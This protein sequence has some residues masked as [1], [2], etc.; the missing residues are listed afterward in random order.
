MAGSL[1][2]HRLRPDVTLV[3]RNGWI[4]LAGSGQTLRLPDTERNRAALFPEERATAPDSAADPA[5]QAALIQRGFLVAEVPDRPEWL[6]VPPYGPQGDPRPERTIRFAT[7][8]E[9]EAELTERLV[10][11]G[12]RPADASRPATPPPEAAERDGDDMADAT[13][14]VVVSLRQPAEILEEVNKDAL[15]RRSLLLAYLIAPAGPFVSMLWPPETACLTCLTLRVRSTFP[16]QDLA[17]RPIGELLGSMG[18]DAQMPARLVG[19][20]LVLH[21]LVMVRAG[22]FRVLPAF[23]RLLQLDIVGGRLVQH[24]VL[25]LPNCP[26]CRPA[27]ARPPRIPEWPGDA[28]P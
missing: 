6:E 20:G 28:L 22:E 21:L 12:L 11:A 3:R 25:R 2:P 17:D 15:A 14:V 10:A 26:S 27:P 7:E 16:W 24:P 4:Y 1:P 18:T 13:T 5:L 23:R 19:L 9:D 8:A